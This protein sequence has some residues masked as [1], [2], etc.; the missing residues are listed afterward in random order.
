MAR[1]F[2]RKEYK[3][4]V[5]RLRQ[6]ASSVGCKEVNRSS[7]ASHRVPVT[8]DPTE[9]SPSTP[10]LSSQPRHP[11]LSY[12][13][14]VSL[15]QRDPTEE[16]RSI[17]KGVHRRGTP[18][19]QGSYGHGGKIHNQ[20]VLVPSNP[21]TERRPSFSSIITNQTNQVQLTIGSTTD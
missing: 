17:L 3:R 10:S 8:Y 4:W 15:Q 18:A 2:P 12:S 5:P 13:F 21:L 14:Y 7:H 16:Q 19:P 6:R 11:T 20:P 9:V 1:P